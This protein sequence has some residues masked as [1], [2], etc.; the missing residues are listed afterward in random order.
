MSKKI[1]ST[2]ERQQIK[3]QVLDKCRIDPT[4]YF[5]LS[6]HDTN[7]ASTDRVTALGDKKIKKRAKQLLKKNLRAMSEA[8]E[9]LYASGTHSML[10]I[11]QAMDAAGK[12]S[13]IKHVMSGVNPQGCQ[14]SSFKKPSTDEA[15]H[16][17]LWRYTKKMPK[18]GMIGIFNRSYY[19]EVL[20]VKV[21]PEFLPINLSNQENI[22]S[23]RYEDINNMERY[24]T[25]NQTVILKF[26]LNVSKQEQGRRF[27][28]RLEDSE[29]HW[30]F[31]EA[32][33]KERAHWD[34]YMNAFESAIRA[35]STPWAPW[36]VIPADFKWGMRSI[37]SQIVTETI[38][39]L[40]LDYPEVTAEKRERLKQARQQLLEE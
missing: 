22:W 6:D 8:Q 24:L 40:D 9:L 29:K 23:R 13:T 5:S 20:V 19:E 15:A 7:W 12:D 17:W 33:L 1:Y 2:E 21:H 26:F 31:S 4:E 36:F 3:E 27:L 28:D 37:V 25:Q 10:L 18:R 35:T 38:L 14:V 16:D 34:Q 32:D 30:K 11:F 39:S